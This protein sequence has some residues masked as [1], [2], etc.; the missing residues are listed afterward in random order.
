VFQER[1]LL[2]GCR[3]V[4]RTCYLSN[5]AHILTWIAPHFPNAQGFAGNL[6]SS[7]VKSARGL[8]KSI[9]TSTLGARNFEPSREV[10]VRLALFEIN[11]K[12]VD[13]PRWQFVARWLTAYP[14]RSDISRTA[15]IYS[16]VL[17]SSLTI[18]SC[19]TWINAYSWFYPYM[20]TNYLRIA[21]YEIV[22]AVGKIE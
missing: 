16:F 5:P 15:L 14:D 12:H 7:E 21:S 8:R 19:S 2:L 20:T 11:W 1:P 6:E 17:L 4:P 9:R 18:R 22:L 3:L 10:G 13:H